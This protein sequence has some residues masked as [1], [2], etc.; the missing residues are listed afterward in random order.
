MKLSTNNKINIK[1]LENINGKSPDLV[2]RTLN[3]K[4]SYAFFESVSSDNKISDFLNK[5]L[6]NVNYYFDNVF[7]KIKN[8]LY[9]SKVKD[10]KN[11]DE[12]YYY[13]ES[14]FTI[15]FINGFSKAVAVETRETLDRGITDVKSEMGIKGPRDSFTENFNNDIIIK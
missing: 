1:K 12:L 9:N 5:A 6:I 13:L 3:K 8:N 14:G 4:I 10:V 11:F 7:N 15:V 2:I